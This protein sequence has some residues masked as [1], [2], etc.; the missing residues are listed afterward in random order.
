MSNTDLLLLLLAIP[1]IAS[2]L[3]FACRALGSAA[4][5]ATT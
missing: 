3:A 1:L 5:M 4:R 2:L